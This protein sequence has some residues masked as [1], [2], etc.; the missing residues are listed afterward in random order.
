MYE[1]VVADTLEKLSSAP[2]C[3]TPCLFEHDAG[4]N[5]LVHRDPHCLLVKQPS[6]SLWNAR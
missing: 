6:S 1:H 4:E 3:T 5:I 2:I